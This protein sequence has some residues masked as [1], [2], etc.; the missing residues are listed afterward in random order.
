MPRRTWRAALATY[1]PKI[2]KEQALVEWSA[3]AASIERMIRAFNPKPC[4][5]TFLPS[6]PD[7]SCCA[8]PGALLKI[9]RAAVETPPPELPSAPPPAP[10]TVLAMKR[11]PLV[12]T[13]DGEPTHPEPEAPHEPRHP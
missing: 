9:L 13:G 8:T 1:A 11:G 2:A 4:C 10:G 5:H 6:G 3:P 12:A 7:P